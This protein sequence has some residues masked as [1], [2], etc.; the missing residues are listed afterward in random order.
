MSKDDPLE[1]TI[2]GR[3]CDYA[4]SRGCLVYKFT[5]PQRAAVPDRLMITPTGVVFFVEFKRAGKVPT[6]AQMREHVRL[7]NYNVQVFVVDSVNSG[8]AMIDWMLEPV[9]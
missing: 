4:K 8:K 3:V 9:E 7:K 6:V 1:K 5:S 2:E